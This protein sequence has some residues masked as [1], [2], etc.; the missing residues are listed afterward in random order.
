MTLKITN[1]SAATPTLLSIDEIPRGAL[2]VSNWAGDNPTPLFRTESG[3]ANLKTGHH[4]T[5][6][7]MRSMGK[8]YRLIDGELIINNK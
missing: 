7:M 1:K 3:F 4:P 6:E 5:V 8:V 2:F